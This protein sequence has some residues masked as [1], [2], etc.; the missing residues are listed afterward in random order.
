LTELSRTMGKTVTLDDIPDT[1]LDRLADM[2]LDW[3]WF[4]SVWQTGTA[5]QRVFAQQ[6]RMAQGIRRDA[7]GLVRG[8]HRRFRVAVTDYTVHPGLGGDAACSAHYGRS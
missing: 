5:A 1:E 2:G 4:L 8:G 3:I 6:R 7:A